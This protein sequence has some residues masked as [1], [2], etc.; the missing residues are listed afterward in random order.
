ME[1]H[2]L[3]GKGLVISVV[4]LFIGVAV[5]PSINFT[6]VK[7]SNDDDLVEVTSQACGINGFGDTTIKLTREQYQNLEQYLV[8][9][10]GRLNQTTTREEAVPIFKEAVMELNTYGLLPKRMDVK[11]AQRIVTRSLYG[12]HMSGVLTRL[13]S[14]YRSQNDSNFNAVC[15]IAGKTNLTCFLSIGFVL[16]ENIFNFLYYNFNLNENLLLLIA[17]L[18]LQLVWTSNI[19]PFSLTNRFYLGYRN[20]YNPDYILMSSGWIT[21]IGSQGIK[22][23]QGDMIGSLP[24]KHFYYS[25]G[26]FPANEYYPAVLGF[27]GIKIRLTNDNF[28]LNKFFYLGSALSVNISTEIP[29]P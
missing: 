10:R 6:V 18:C 28:F 21:T 11:Q 23:T 20:L 25:G 19:N 2:P 14:A 5:A 22:R 4:I 3:W 26:P 16:L 8:D 1:L 27:L 15:L 13:L 7:A 9:F 24:I 29:S 12:S 17:F